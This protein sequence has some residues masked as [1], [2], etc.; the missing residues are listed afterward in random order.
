MLPFNCLVLNCIVLLMLRVLWWYCEIQSEFIIINSSG[1]F[2]FLYWLEIRFVF[3]NHSEFDY[4]EC[5]CAAYGAVSCLLHFGIK[6]L[7]SADGKSGVFILLL[8]F[9]ML[10]A[11]HK[12]FVHCCRVSNRIRFPKGCGRSEL[13]HGSDKLLLIL[14]SGFSRSLLM[15]WWIKPAVSFIL[16]RKLSYG[17]IEGV[18]PVRTLEAIEVDQ[19][20]GLY[21]PTYYYF[22]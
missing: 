10:G 6:P 3:A 9:R 13:L 18:V 22:G 12:C 16:M 17:P 7:K 11:E 5:Y 19:Y 20:Y 14:F 21:F 2:S 15:Q 4:C 8:C 1:I